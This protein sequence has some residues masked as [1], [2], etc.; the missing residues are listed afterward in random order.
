M[1]DPIFE[2]C[3]Y[4]AV[5]MNDDLHRAFMEDITNSSHVVQVDT[6]LKIY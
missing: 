2:G 3:N 5:N 4:S 6:S 1:N